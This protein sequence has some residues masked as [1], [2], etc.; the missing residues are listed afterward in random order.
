[1]KQLCIVLLLVAAATDGQEMLY[2]RHGN[3]PI[4]VPL[5]EAL[6]S[7]GS[8]R[9]DR[10]DEWARAGMNRH[11]K[12]KKEYLE[13][14]PESAGPICQGER[15]A[16]LPGGHTVVELTDNSRAIIVGQVVARNVGFFDGFPGAL[17]TVA[18]EKEVRA[19]TDIRPRDRRVLLYY[20]EA[21]FTVEG[22]SFCT[23][24]A[25]HPARPRA[26]DRVLMFVIGQPVDFSGRLIYTQAS[27]QLV[28]ET[29]DGVM[30]PTPDLAPQL[31]RDGIGDLD[32]LVT[33]ISGR[34]AR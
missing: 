1:M 11:R 17:L 22:E 6:D 30:I 9:T 16:E 23:V 3:T 27:Q 19:S 8:M 14:H 25:R 12:T 13:K 20:P 4:W 21:E 7:N 15:P 29:K 10:F 24:P 32:E 18:I 33:V 2:G 34:L 26:G 5:A 28:F 31:A